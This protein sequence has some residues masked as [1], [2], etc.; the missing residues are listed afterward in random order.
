MPEGLRKHTLSVF[1]S[2]QGHINYVFYLLSYFL[3]CLNFLKLAIVLDVFNLPFR[4]L[5]P[6]FLVFQ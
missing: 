5:S 3:L 6:T 4:A 2:S 1:H